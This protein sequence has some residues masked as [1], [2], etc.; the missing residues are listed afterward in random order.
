MAGSLDEEDD[1]DEDD[2][3][4][5]AE[6]L[7]RLALEDAGRGGGCGMSSSSS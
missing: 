7:E 6:G 1:E 2:V 3:A 4:G 5:G